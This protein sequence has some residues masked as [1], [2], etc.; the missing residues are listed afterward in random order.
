[1][2]EMAI[3]YS[4]EEQIAEEQVYAG[5]DLFRYANR[6]IL[7]LRLPWVGE[8]DLVCECASPACF[9]VLRIEP[10]AY[11]AVCSEPLEFVVLPGHDDPDS[12]EVVR[13][14]SRY[15]VIRHGPQQEPTR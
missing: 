7:E 6:K 15:V 13:T 5:P 8:Y 14:T 9:E 11:E 4:V 12:D 10:E 1:L 3:H 2:I